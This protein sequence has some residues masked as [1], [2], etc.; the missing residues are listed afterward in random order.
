MQESQW[1]REWAPLVADDK[2]DGGSQ[3]LA[4]G[5]RALEIVGTAESSMTVARL[6]EELDIHRSMAY[7][8]V[9]TLELH[10]FIDR[11]ASGEL[12]LGVKLATL[13]RSVAKTLQEAAAPELADLAAR[14][15]MT[16]FL[17]TYDGDSVVTLSSSEPQN[18]ETTVAKRPGSRHSIDRGAPGKV[19][20][21]Q[22]DPARFPPQ[23]FEFSQDEVI[24]G[25]ASIAVPLA[26]SGNSPAALAVIF[27]PQP[28]DREEIASA[29]AEAAA[30]I[31]RALGR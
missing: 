25:V 14:F 23:S 29:L 15:E 2:T 4:R 20:R 31:R 13:A 19:V 18:V 22:L 24:P 12:T 1:I 5:L 16:A 26:I 27:L 30:R 17:A 6:G 3:T 7:R 10:G 28:I 9:K 11:H 8:L 21:S